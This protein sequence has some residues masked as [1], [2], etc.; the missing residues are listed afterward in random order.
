MKAGS[1]KKAPKVPNPSPKDNYM[2]ESDQMRRVPMDRKRKL[3]K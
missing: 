1:P 3:S 2:R